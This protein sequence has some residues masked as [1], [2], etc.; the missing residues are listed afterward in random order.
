[1]TRHY[2][3]LLLQGSKATAFACW[4]GRGPANPAKAPHQA[5][6]GLLNAIQVMYTTVVPAIIFGFEQTICT[7]PFSKSQLRSGSALQA[8]EFGRFEVTKTYW[9]LSQAF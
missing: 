4:W 2:D 3:V 9:K 8:M 5:L 6:I 1:M 7:S